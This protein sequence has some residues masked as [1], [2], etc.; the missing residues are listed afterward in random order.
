MRFSRIKLFLP[1]GI[2]ILIIFL[3]LNLIHSSNNQYHTEKNII[4]T[5]SS[6]SPIEYIVITETPVP[7]PTFTPTPTRT[8]TPTPVPILSNDLET[9]FGKYSSTY[10]T[11]KELLRK[12]AF[13]ESKFNPNASNGP[14]AGLYQFTEGS[15]IVTRRR[16]GLDTNPTLR[17]NPE[18]AIKTAAFKISKDGP[19]AWPNCRK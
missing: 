17:L 1:I 11:D 5:S 7:T 13:C 16:M 4:D 10:N 9:L 6:I 2:L 14:Y 3:I 12:I 8:P 19:H 18:E 15:W